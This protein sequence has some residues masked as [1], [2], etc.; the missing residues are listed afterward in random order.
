MSKIFDKYLNVDNV[1]YAHEEIIKNNA[2]IYKKEEI[3]LNPSHAQSTKSTK[4]QF[5]A[6][7]R[8]LS[9]SWKVED[10]LYRPWC[11]Y[12]NEPVFELNECPKNIWFKIKHNTE[13][14]I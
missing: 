5:P 7:T 6:C 4:H 9:Y 2:N 13:R 10:N 12:S 3:K 8:C 11:K 1:D 14:D